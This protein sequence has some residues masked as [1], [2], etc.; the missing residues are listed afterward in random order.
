M[1]N[2]LHLPTLDTQFLTFCILTA[3]RL[4]FLGNE[5]LDMSLQPFSV[6]FRNDKNF[7]LVY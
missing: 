3:R 4:A 2:R 1:S 6:D 5:E 7:P